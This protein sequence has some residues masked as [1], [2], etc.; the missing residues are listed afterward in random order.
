MRETARLAVV[1]LGRAGMARCRAIQA[2]PE[3]E[4][5]AVHSRRP[6][7][8]PP[9]PHRAVE[10]ICQDASIDAVIISCENS[11]HA[12]LARRF[13]EARKDVLVE[14][15]LAAHRAEAAAL[16]QLAASKR[17]TL[18]V[19]L[20]GRLTAQHQMLRQLS[21]KPEIRGVSLSFSGS[22][23]RW[24]HTEAM[25]G[26]WGRLAIGRLHALY[27]LFGPL[28]LED[29][30]LRQS[31]N[32]GYSLAL[33][34]SNGERQIHLCEDRSPQQRRS[35]AWRFELA[36]GET[37]NPTLPAG[38]QQLFELDLRSFLQERRGLPALI[39]RVSS[40]EV[41]TVLKLAEE[42]DQI[43]QHQRK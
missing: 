17:K 14:Y 16:F 10:E 20:I 8:E 1:G 32:G 3:A 27:D 33:H 19:E 9:A 41:L 21:S 37:L 23:Y 25:R 12:P 30:T 38:P 22:L 34:L 29:L 18:S 43:A 15:P 2:I 31:K 13:L 35:T 36:G 5:A 28:T 4:L 11:R 24:V 7:G 40:E 42:I 26:H 39:E 6:T